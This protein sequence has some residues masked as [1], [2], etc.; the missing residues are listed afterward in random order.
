MSV[1]IR[2]PRLAALTRRSDLG[3]TRKSD[4]PPA[5]SVLPPG[6]DLVGLHAQVRKVPILLQKSVEAGRGR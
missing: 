5:K 1:R 3:Q 6:A 2:L 4:R